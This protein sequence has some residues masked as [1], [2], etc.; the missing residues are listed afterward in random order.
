[1]SYVWEKLYQAVDDLVTCEKPLR[2][3]LVDVCT[4]NLST[5]DE[6]HFPEENQKDEFRRFID[7][8]TTCNAVGSEGMV[9]VTIYKM[10]NYEVLE[11]VEK[12]LSM[13]DKVAEH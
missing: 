1:M 2:K 9:Q 13:Y 11:M 12:I 5:L 6:S 3:C 7:S 4:Y 8:I 10:N